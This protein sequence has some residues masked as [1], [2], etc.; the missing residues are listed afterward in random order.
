MA[1]KILWDIKVKI[2]SIN[3][4]REVVQEDRREEY[5]TDKKEQY[6]GEGI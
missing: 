3:D 6:K 1:E 5:E 4:M 2:D